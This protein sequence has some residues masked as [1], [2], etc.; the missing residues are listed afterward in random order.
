MKYRFAAYRALWQRYRQVFAHFWRERSSLD[1]KL[2]TE[3]EA[4][5]LPA[6]LAV[7]E[8]PLSRT[9]RLTA[10]TLMLLVLILLLW[11]VLGKIDIVVNA[12]GKVIPQSY[13]KSVSSVEVAFVRKLYVA[14]GQSVHAGD[15]L[16]DLDASSAEAEH[17]KAA[18]DVALARLQIARANA[19]LIA[20]EQRHAPGFARTDGMPLELWRDAQQHAQAQYDDYV[21]KLERLE[22]GISRYESQLPLLAKRA[23]DYRSLVLSQDVP[24]HAWIEKQQA[25]LDI[26]GQLTDMRRQRQVLISDTRKEARDSLV[27]G[28]R[29][30]A[31]S[32]QDAKRMAEHAKLLTLNAPVD[33]TV[34]QL[35][36]HTVGGV[37]PAAQPLMV[38]VPKDGQLA[39]EAQM[40]N[41]DVGFVREGQAVAVKIET[42]E[43]TKYGTIPAHVA[44]VSRD[45]VED[46]KKNLLY[47]VKIQLDRDHMIIDGKNQQ[48]SA[49]MVAN[50]EIKTGERRII[51]YVLSPLLQH[52]RETLRER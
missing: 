30:A 39:I 37:V 7:Q 43:Y 10:R 49:G 3:H 12:K 5:F 16:M 2:L 17:D 1:G 34:Q 21:A 24:E 44:H 32:E 35:V 46:D 8:R 15:R 18:G 4:E 14:E 47:M 22:A 28:L 40:E 27:E 52:Q 41:R 50:V 48:L 23:E 20:V 36:A 19:L 25:Y 51:E 11:S 38:I 26:Q 6:A 9:I 31:E 29:L 33:G 42:F 45:A 13:T